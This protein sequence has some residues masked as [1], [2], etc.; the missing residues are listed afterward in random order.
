[1]TTCT[2]V[3]GSNRYICMKLL[4]RLF[5]SYRILLTS[6][7]QSLC[8]MISSFSWNIFFRIF[9]EFSF[10]LPYLLLLNSFTFQNIRVF[11]SLSFGYILI[12]FLLC[13]KCLVFSSRLLC[14][15]FSFVLKSGSF[16]TN[17][18]VPLSLIFSFILKTRSFRTDCFASSF[19]LYEGSFQTYCFAS[20]SFAFNEGSFLADCFVSLSFI[21]SFILKTGSF[22]TDCFVSLPLIFLLF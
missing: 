8:F 7:W 1:M 14:F 19:A 9:M 13:F 18:F 12:Y 16:L 17:C 2:N 21:L 11:P 3:Y 4:N 5:N 22:L 20:L 6:F 15:S 10:L